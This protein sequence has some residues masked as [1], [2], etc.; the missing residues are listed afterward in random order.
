M[1]NLLPVIAVAH[2]S[3]QWIER[4]GCGV[5]VNSLDG[6]EAAADR[7]SMN[8]ATYVNNVKRVYDERLDFNGA[9][10]PV[11]ARLEIGDVRE[12]R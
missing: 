8:Y 3:L 2:P 6:I 4:E 12:R 10:A 11:L 1:K 5:L 9:F 7:I